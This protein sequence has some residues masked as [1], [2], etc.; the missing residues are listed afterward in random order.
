MGR[1]SQLSHKGD[2]EVRKKSKR[3]QL[4]DRLGLIETDTDE[5]GKEG[6]WTDCLVV[7]AAPKL[8]EMCRHRVKYQ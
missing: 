4:A 1:R 2:A 5:M 8:D 6:I 7:G 3:E